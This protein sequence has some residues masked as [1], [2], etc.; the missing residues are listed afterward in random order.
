VFVL[1]Q[2]FLERSGRAAHPAAGWA[3]PLAVLV[4]GLGGAVQPLPEDALGGVSMVTAAYLSPTQNLG[5]MLALLLAVVCVD[6]LRD[7]RPRTRWILLVL[8]ALAA[9]G[10]KATVLPLV[11]CG[12]GLVFLVRLVRGRPTR[13]ALIGGV[14][15][16][17]IFVGSVIA[18][19]GGESSGLQVK[20]GAIFLQLAPYADLRHGAGLDRP[21]QLLSAAATLTGWGLAVAGV[22]FLRRFWRDP[23]TVFLAGASIGAFVAMLLTTQPGISQ[24]YFYRTALPLLAVLSCLGLAHLV[25]RLGDRRAAVLVGAASV[26]GF[27]ACLLARA[28]ANGHTGV[29]VPFAWTLGALL[30]V[31][32]VLALGWRLARRSGSV[33]TAFLAAAVAACMVGATALPL[34]G[35]VSD[36]ASLVIYGRPG[37]YGPTKAQAD[38]ARWLRDHTGR[39]DLVATNAHCIVQRGTVC[40]NRHFWIAALSER[41]V[42]VE[43]WAYTNRINRISVATGVNPNL[44]PFWDEQLLAA[45]D[46]AFVAPSAAVIDRLRRYG[47]RWLYADGRAGRISPELKQFVRLR[48]A[49]LDATI[50][51]IT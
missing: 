26:L 21:A 13:T 28:M 3:G 5:L 44:L 35:L 46:A 7:Q 18:I 48:H 20:P 37:K 23:G 34:S 6:L 45:N 12:F 39:D 49:T 10:A 11:G 50:Y 16:V 32:V 25:E 29:K 2:R 24:I 43:G 41:Q 22:L 33:L 14:L 42:L 15:T 9:S 36:Q 19:F 40:D 8:L 31:G 4:A 1:T 38:A 47:V 17:L 30:A 27:A 51:E